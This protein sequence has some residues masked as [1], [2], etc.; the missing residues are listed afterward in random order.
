[1]IIHI[2]F[3]QSL[4][5]LDEEFRENHAET[6]A[7]F[8]AAF[9]SEHQYVMELNRLVEELEEGIFL[10]Q[11]LESVMACEEGKQLMVC[12]KQVFVSLINVSYLII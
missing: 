9:E 11:S 5:E 6:L 10:Q 4:Q 8:Y 7:R 12:F 2:L 1:L 3:F